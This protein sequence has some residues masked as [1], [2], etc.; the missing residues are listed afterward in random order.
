MILLKRPEKLAFLD[1]ATTIVYEGA[2]GK[3]SLK[4]WWMS[5]PLF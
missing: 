4:R 3:M 5:G 1:V 2:Q